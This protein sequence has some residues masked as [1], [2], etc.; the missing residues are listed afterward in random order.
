M[1]MNKIFLIG[2]S[3]LPLC[4]SVQGSQLTETALQN[5]LSSKVKTVKSPEHR[6]AMLELYTSEGCSS[7]PPAEKFL[8][9]LEDMGI[10]DEQLVPMAF[11]VTYWDYIGWKDRFASKQFDERQRSLANKNNKHT[12]YTPQF[13]FS[14]K[15][16]RRYAHFSEDVRGV[17]AQ[18]SPVDLELTGRL[19]PGSERAEKIWINLKTDITSSK[20]SNI[21]FYIAV[22]ENNL[23]S[24]VDDGE[25]SGKELQH[26]YVVRQL[27][28]PYYHDQAD[29]VSLETDR[30]IVLAPEWKRQDLSI[31]AFAEDQQT[32]EILQAVRLEF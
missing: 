26:D 20:Q 16:Y 2:F 13:V 28:G 12:V 25:N 7:C 11:H 21:G 15:D 14:G 1:L 4:L 27:H 29:D 8:S 22:L 17:L 9:E 10:S 31:V 18:R 30:T 5:N 19:L 32:G 23:S 3:L 6:V 24:M